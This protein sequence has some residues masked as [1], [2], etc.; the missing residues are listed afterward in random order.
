MGDFIISNF[1]KIG[2]NFFI[3]I[4]GLA[5]GSFLNVCVYR[6]PR[7]QSIVKPRSSCTN[8]NKLIPWYDNIPLLSYIILGGK[9][10]NCKN[11]ISFQY[12]IVELLTG[13]MFLLLFNRFGLNLVSLIYIIFVCGLIVATFVDF[14]FRIIPDEINIGGMILALIISVIYPHLHGTNNHLLGLLRSFLGLLAGGGIIW[15]TGIIGDFIFK[16][17]TM[18][19]GDVKLLAMIGAFLGWQIAILTFF[20]APILGAVVGIIIKLKTKSSLIA[21]GPYL[22]LASIVSLLWKDEILTW[23]LYR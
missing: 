18:G 1:D 10:R 6:M 12:F 22:S 13:S 17:E 21:Y 3:F 20:I 14:N 2:I 9:C 16:K 11:K 15:L 4:F 23:L 5:V 19:G 8:C 7:E